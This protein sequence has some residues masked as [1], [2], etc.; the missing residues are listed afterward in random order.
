MQFG[1]DALQ[2]LVKMK[3]KMYVH[4]K[5]GHGRAP[6]MVA[7]YLISQGKSV[8]EALALIKKKRPSIHIEKVQKKALQTFLKNLS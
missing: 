7:A 3:K 5:N 2:K 1:A 8:D 6:T 4:C